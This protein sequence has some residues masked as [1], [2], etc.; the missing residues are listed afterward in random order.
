MV[1]TSVTCAGEMDMVIN[2]T[3]VCARVLCCR[4]LA[5]VGSSLV[6]SRGVTYGNLYRDHSPELNLG[7]SVRAQHT[8]CCHICGE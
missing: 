1:Q 2:I 6:S 8:L 4:V 5:G 3:C 7:G